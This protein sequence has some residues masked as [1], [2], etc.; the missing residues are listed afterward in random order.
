MVALTGAAQGS[1]RRS[2]FD[3]YLG[4]VSSAEESGLTKSALRFMAIQCF[5]QDFGIE[6][7]IYPSIFH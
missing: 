7:R 2:L 4:L 1:S 3:E 6:G 5:Y